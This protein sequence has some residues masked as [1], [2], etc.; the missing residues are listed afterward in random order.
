MDSPE[1]YSRVKL[2]E[3]INSKNN[4]NKYIIDKNSNDEILAIQQTL[5]CNKDAFSVIVKKYTPMLYTLAY[6]M[7]GNAEDAEDVVQEIFLR[8]YKSLARFR[9]G[10]KFYPWIYTIAINCTRTYLRRKKKKNANEILQSETTFMIFSQDNKT[11]NPSDILEVKE[12]EKIAQKSIMALKPKYREVFVLRHIEGLSTLDVAEILNIP[13]G[14]VKIYLHRA[15]K[16]IIKK[17]LH[18]G[19]INSKKD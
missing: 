9:L 6:R 2:T 10:Q 5:Q 1:K 18:E 19:W 8:V 15:R 11:K 16:E 4:H 12:G 13:E 7:L 3:K 14:T 17:F